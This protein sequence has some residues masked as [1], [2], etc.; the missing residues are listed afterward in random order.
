MSG[1]RSAFSFFTVLPI[2]GELEPD[3]IAYLPFVSLFD[4]AVG[5]SL[6]VAVYRYSILMASFLSISSIYMLN[7]L[8]HVDAVTDTGDALM[9][10]D[11]TR[12][13]DVL[14]D[15]HI[16][17]GGLFVFLFIY[18]LSFIS[19]S[20]NR[21]YMAIASIITAEFLSKSTMMLIL[22]RSRPLFEGIGSA[23]IDMY[24]RHPYAYTAEFLII[25]MAISLIFPAAII[26][27]TVLT[28]LFY[29]ILRK[30][31][32]LKF[33]G[34]NGDIAGFTGETVRSILIFTVFML[35]QSSMLSTYDIL[36]KIISLL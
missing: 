2:K 15:H 6:Y 11:K 17:A 20:A 34:I 7:G 32:N 23:F 21:P 9:V 33:G 29:V 1:F 35:S 26:L 10:R 18:L 31:L 12:L 13:K 27:A 5:V 25:P 24:K 4:A 30:L 8:N 28:L 22:H 36:S 16:G 19:L 3:L 14:L